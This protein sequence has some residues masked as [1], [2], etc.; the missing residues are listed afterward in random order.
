[1]RFSDN[2][3]CPSPASVSLS[4]SFTLRLARTTPCLAREESF[5]LASDDTRPLSSSSISRLCFINAPRCHFVFV[6]LMARTF[7]PFLFHPIPP[8]SRPLSR[9]FVISL[10]PSRVRFCFTD[11]LLPLSFFLRLKPPRVSHFNVTLCPPS[12]FSN[13]SFSPSIHHPLHASPLPL[14]LFLPL[15]PSPTNSRTPSA[16]VKRRFRADWSCALGDAAR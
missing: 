2:P 11:P 13:Q 6:P 10:Q 12:S 4:F 16:V 3:R 1:M 9:P 7:S 14:S 5:H 8:P 15:A